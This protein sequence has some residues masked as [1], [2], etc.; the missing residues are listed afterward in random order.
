MWLLVHPYAHQAVAGMI[1]SDLGYR[2]ALVLVFIGAL[3][4]SVPAAPSGLG[5]FHAS[6]VSGFLLLGRDAGAGLIF[7]VA[8]H[9]LFFIVFGLSGLAVVSFDAHRLSTRSTAPGGLH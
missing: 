6:I 2:E 1:G 3:R 8:V 7:A 5:T 4:L 9:G